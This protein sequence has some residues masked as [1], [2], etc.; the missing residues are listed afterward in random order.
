MRVAFK[1]MGR[2]AEVG[3]R[4]YIWAASAGLET[5][6]SYIEHCNSGTPAAIVGSEEGKAL[7]KKIFTELI[8]VLEKISPGIVQNI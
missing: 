5:C 3:S 7:Q 2:T 8:E 6:G 1:A 4:N